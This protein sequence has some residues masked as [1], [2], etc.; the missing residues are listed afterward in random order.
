M[1]A[2]S[3]QGVIF[4]LD[5]TLGD[6]LPVC[7]AAF[8]ETFRHYLGREYGDRE[9]RAM[10]GPSEEGILQDLLA[11]R[12]E[13]GLRHY[14]GAYRAAHA[15]CPAPFPGINEVLRDLKR[16]GIAMAIVTGKGPQSAG[17]S[18]VALGLEDLFDVVEAGS[19]RGGVKP[20]AMQRVVAAWGFD[21]AHVA[22]LGDAPSDIRSAHEIGAIALG[23]AWAPTADH[24]LL[25]SYNPHALFRQVSEFAAW[26]GER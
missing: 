2:M 10:F 8:R 20:Q 19:A 25:A 11:D 17:I 21:L 1:P 23:A 18:L 16:R 15:Q 4:D 14:L 26:V 5:G 7:F 24:D 6:T 22:C 13:E 12:W 9:I 3:L